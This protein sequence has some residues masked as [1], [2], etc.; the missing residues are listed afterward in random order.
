M[1]KPVV[2][3]GKTYQF[4]DDATEAE[5]A[6][7][8]GQLSAP[9]G[10]APPSRD[11]LG[12]AAHDVRVG[13]DALGP[14]AAAAAGG[15][16][17]GGPPGAA[18]GAGALAASDALIGLRNLV[19]PIWGGGPIALPSEALRNASRAI[20]L[21]DAPETPTERVAHEALSGGAQAVGGAGA[22]RSV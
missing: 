15:A 2:F 16:A 5:I 1:A 22:A 11:A 9:T 12:Q 20:G 17:V 10:A 7:A 3:E 21:T 4:P 6:E 8:L 14:Y 13:S 18:A 19:A